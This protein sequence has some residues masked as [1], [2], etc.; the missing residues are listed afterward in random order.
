MLISPLINRTLCVAG[1]IHSVVS[2]QGSKSAVIYRFLGTTPAASTLR[3]VLFSICQQLYA[4]AGEDVDKVPT[5]EKVRLKL[6]LY[7]LLPIYLGSAGFLCQ[8][9]TSCR[10][11]SASVLVFRFF[12]SNGGEWL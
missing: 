6:F 8:S 1:A 5:A 3:S 7:S 11:K 10:R 2:K 9:T 4:I 12:G